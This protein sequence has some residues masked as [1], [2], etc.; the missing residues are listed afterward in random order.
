MKACRQDNNNDFS[1]LKKPFKDLI[2]AQVSLGKALANVLTAGADTAFDTLR[3]MDLNLPKSKS[4]CD[5]PEP[6]WMA[7][8]LGEAKCQLAPDASGEIRF[9]VANEDYKARDFIVQASGPHASLVSITDLS[10]VLGPKE[11]KTV[12]ARFVMPSEGPQDYDL[13][14]WVKGCSDHYLRW[15]ITR[16]QETQACCYEVDVNDQPDYVVHW[17]D[18]FYCMKPCHGTGRS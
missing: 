18:H 4:C 10:F 2:A 5:V 12:T 15:V 11:R 7:K 9:I 13:L 14:L 3:R 8:S 17:Y 1:E 16:T 6:C